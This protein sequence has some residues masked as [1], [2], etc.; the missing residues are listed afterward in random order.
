MVVSIRV[1]AVAVS[2]LLAPGASWSATEP[3]LGA[4]QVLERLASQ[5]PGAGEV[6]AKN[7]PVVAFIEDLDRYAANPGAPAAAAEG[8][9][10]LYAR[11]EKLRSQVDSNEP[12]HFDRKLKARLSTHSLLV[13]LPPPEAWPE[14][15]KRLRKKRDLGG[16]AGLDVLG[17]AL[18]GGPMPKALER[19]RATIARLPHDKRPDAERTVQAIQF[20]T[21]ADESRTVIG[22]FER[23]LEKR[24]AL[25]RATSTL[26]VPDLVTLV[27]IERATQLLTRA[28]LMPGTSIS[29]PVGDE[30]RGLA[31]K[32]LLANVKQLRVP[33]WGLVRAPNAK[34]VYEAITTQ[35]PEAAGST[36]SAEDVFA[37]HD[38]DDDIDYGQLYQEASA[39][40]EAQLHYLAGLIVAGDADKAEPLAMRLLQSGE[41]G[42]AAQALGELRRE[43]F[44]A[45]L[46]GFFKVLLQRNPTLPGW[47]TLFELAAENGKTG[48]ALAL[49]ERALR[50][51]TLSGAAKRELQAQRVN[52]LLAADKV[53]EA[54]AEIDRLLAAAENQD[55]SLAAM[56]TGL[57]LQMMNVGRLTGDA[58]RLRK[59]VTYASG[60][61]AKPWPEEKRY[62]K[63]RTATEVIKALRQ[64]GQLAEAEKV[65]LGRLKE[66]HAGTDAEMMSAFAMPDPRLR[67]MLAELAGIYAQAGR[68]DDVLLLIERAPLWGT[69][70]LASVLHQA[71]SLKTPLGHMAGRALIEKGD[72]VR[73][74]PILE[75]VLTQAGG[76]DP[77]YEAYVQ[78]FPETAAT[79]L[80]ELYRRDR[81][82][83]RPLIWKSV[84]LVRAGKVAEA[85]AVARQAIA[86]D[87]SDGEQGAGHR[88]R[89]Y[90]ILADALQQ[91]GQVETAETYRGAVRAIR[92]SEDADALRLAGLH[93]RAIALYAEA[94]GEFSDAYCIQSRLAVE[95][96]HAGRHQE[97]EQ[98]YRRAYEL[99]PD[100]FGRVESHCFGCE[101]VFESPKAQS[102]AESVFQALLKKAPDK[103]Q[104]H[105]LMGYLRYEQGRHGEALEFFRAAVAIDPD[106]LNAWKKLHEVAERIHVDRSERDIV[107]MKI[108]S[109]DPQLRHSSPDFAQMLDLKRLWGGVDAAQ[110][111]AAPR[112]GQLLPLTASAAQRAEARAKLPE[113]MRRSIEMSLDMYADFEA[114]ARQ[115]L[116]EPGT[117]IGRTRLVQSI[118]GLIEQGR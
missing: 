21:A 74:K 42:K 66:L 15:D 6:A 72:Q 33:H 98:H 26:E 85:E 52:A 118:A 64:A 73:A 44:S 68:W 40:T 7:D 59:G 111:L 75:A 25:G 28:L 117:A 92:M 103:A 114:E 13:R 14:L 58:K 5:K 76:F 34:A 53:G 35:F 78:A 116:P 2:C 105:Y 24:A 46:Y 55:E 96:S 70:D 91:R 108:L 60:Q 9:I 8:W 100:S 10:A 99:M 67:P 113:A 41:F 89:V 43:G 109:L 110:R 79:F 29:V 20:L 18:T 38:Y 48:E 3:L 1:A 87:P 62:E 77:A 106:Y 82:E 17:T 23:E 107:A 49:V 71:D 19:A 57:A 11:W 94:L 83:E 51:P 101:K 32:I 30:T 12:A 97:A 69:D 37:R 81:F 61:L 45:E 112:P 86:I 95:L 50:S 80:D 102:V 93:A 63:D 84:L 88:M 115:K 65:V 22:A 54:L 104:V 39:R 4:G 56:R 47:P 31:Q 90:A 27:G 16:A 36:E